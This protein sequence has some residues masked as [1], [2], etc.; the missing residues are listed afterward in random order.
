MR[1][2]IR[3]HALYGLLLAALAGQPS[4]E[5]QCPPG[6]IGSC[7][8]AH[9]TPGCSDLVC[10]ST[11]CS[12]EPTCCTVSWDAPCV[13]AANLLCQ[14][15]GSGNAGS[16]FAP[17]STPAC[18]NATCCALVCGAD[19]YC[20]QVTWD[21]TCVLGATSLCGG[22]S[23]TCGDPGAGSCTQPH[24]TPACSDAA[25]CNAVCAVDPSCCSQ[26]WD[27]FCVSVAAVA[28][29]SDCVPTCPPGAGDESEICGQS[30][31]AP[32][33]GGQAGSGI[34]S[35]AP[36]QIFCGRIAPLESGIDTDAF[37]VQ[38]SDTNGDGLV[39]LSVSL[40]SS[41]GS[42]VAALPTPC[43]PL[44]NAT[45][46]ASVSGCLS[47]SASLCVP[48]G[49]WYLVVARGTFPAPAAPGGDCGM[50]GFRYTLS[51]QVQDNCQD[52]CG[53]GPSCLV[54]HGTP[55]CSDAACC[56][57]VCAFDPLC[58][59]KSWDQLCVDRAVI[60]CDVAAPENDDC[61]D[62]TAIAGA[63]QVPFSVAGATGTPLAP[64]PGC[65]T[66]GSAALGADV[67]FS[68]SGVQGPVELTTC[69][70]PGF[71]TA[72]IVYRGGCD[73]AAIACSDDDPLCPGNP[74]A[75]TVQFSAACGE[76]YLVRVAGVGA[77][78]GAGTLVVRDLGEPCSACAADLTRDG[79]VDGV[80]LSALL[81]A[82]GSGAADLTGDGTVDGVDLTVMLAAWGS[83]QP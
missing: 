58:C 5:A 39:R 60:D 2:A 73:G 64:P 80:D 4:A 30:A 29:S 1:A 67:W 82:W 77:S 51:A 74:L 70:S 25:C 52:A 45:F 14:L 78:A 40:T 68:I 79:A 65:L 33:V 34:V 8:S 76:S 61:Y 15:C 21:T 13:D 49:T 32:C 19:P 3:L 28:C 6:A 69:G 46:H 47:G 41:G 71:D 9:P 16:C 22:G 48:P 72:V 54:P 53:S 42:F 83:C 17:H 38:V 20:C 35:I 62:A 27:L 63:A 66:A 75:S 12:I 26:S 10:C 59:N 50:L 31:N 81:A 37:R 44:Q 7:L 55:G 11:V 43:T 57:E 18:N 23:G 24:P 36:G 56:A